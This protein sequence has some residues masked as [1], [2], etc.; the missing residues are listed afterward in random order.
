MPKFHVVCDC[1]TLRRVVLEVNASS[2]EQ[3]C[4]KIEESSDPDADFREVGPFD[5]GTSDFTVRH[6][7]PVKPIKKSASAHRATD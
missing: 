2:A 4:L 5:E 3:A 1:T 6:A 7:A